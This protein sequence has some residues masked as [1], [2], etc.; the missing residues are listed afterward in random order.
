[1]TSAEGDEA[2]TARRA[3][4]ALPGVLDVHVDQTGSEV[5]FAAEPSADVITQAH[6]LLGT[7]EVRVVWYEGAHETLEPEDPGS[8]SGQEPCGVCGRGPAPW[9]HTAGTRTGAAVAAATS[10]N[11][12]DQCH[13]LLEAE[14][15]QG[16]ASRLTVPDLSDDQRRELVTRLR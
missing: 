11:L 2:A 14:E 13:E 9:P 12:C 6:D 7:E 1:M 4:L 15:F 16:L 3:V 10:W 5:T 8:L